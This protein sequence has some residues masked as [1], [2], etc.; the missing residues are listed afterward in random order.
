M[1]RY[2]STL[3]Y[4]IASNLHLKSLPALPAGF[5]HQDGCGN[6][7]VEGFQLSVHGNTDQGVCLITEFPAQTVPFIADQECAPF[8][9]IFF[10]VAVF[11]LQMGCIRADAP[12][13]Q[14][15][16][17][18]LQTLHADKRHPV[19]GT[20]GGA[21]GLGIVKVYTVFA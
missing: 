14:K 17:S 7:R 11:S 18:I 8:S 16:Q 13:F 21:D 4:K 15:R 2:L 1:L 3:Y 19:N 12:F 6:R 9:V 5:V 20:H 10:I